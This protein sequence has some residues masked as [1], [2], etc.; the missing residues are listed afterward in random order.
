MA[1]PLSRSIGRDDLLVIS[2]TSSFSS[3]RDSISSMTSSRFFTPRA[4]PF[5]LF[6]GSL[7]QL[8]H[9]VHFVL[10]DLGLPD[11][12]TCVEASRHEREGLFRDRLGLLERRGEADHRE[13]PRCRRVQMT[14]LLVD[15]GI[16]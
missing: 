3:R 1:P 2:R 7:T 12:P 15:A 8:A 11:V 4:W 10:D 16:E 5:P 14:G 13:G 9:A 6:E